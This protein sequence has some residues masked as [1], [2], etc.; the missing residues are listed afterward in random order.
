MIR[1]YLEEKSPVMVDSAGDQPDG[2]NVRLKLELELAEVQHPRESVQV[3]QLHCS[4][5]GFAH[6][7]Y[8]HIHAHTTHYNS[9]T[10]NHL[11]C[12]LMTANDLIYDFIFSS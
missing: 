10:P 8:N 4:T 3:L 5:H 6:H 2:N 7:P 9:E 11:A 1:W 12:W